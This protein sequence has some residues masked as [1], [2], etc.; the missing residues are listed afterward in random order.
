[1][2]IQLIIDDEDIKAIFNDLTPFNLQKSYKKIFGNSYKQQL[3]FLEREV[4]LS[5]INEAKIKKLKISV[6]YKKNDIFIC[7]VRI[8]GKY[9]KGI[10]T[11]M[12]CII[13]IDEINR[14]GFLLEIYKKSNQT[15]ISTSQLNKL[16]PLF[17]NYVEKIDN[18]KD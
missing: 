17:L 1:M 18:N 16:K 15:D 4:A 12:R 13:L 5:L 3:C 10:S 7:K 14:Y 6:D 2:Q 8:K 9:T 11:D